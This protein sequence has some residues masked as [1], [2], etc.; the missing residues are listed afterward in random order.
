MTQYIARPGDTMD[1]TISSTSDGSDDTIKVT[2]D[3]GILMTAPTLIFFTGACDTPELLTYSCTPDGSGNLHFQFDVPSSTLA[4]SIIDISAL[5]V[6]TE[7]DDEIDCA[8]DHQSILVIDDSLPSPTP[9]PGPSPTPVPTEACADQTCTVP[10]NLDA[11]CGSRDVTSAAAICILG[12]CTG[13]SEGIDVDCESTQCDDP[14][15]ENGICNLCTCA[16]GAMVGPLMTVR[17]CTTIDEITPAPTPAVPTP[18][19]TPVPTLPAICGNGIT[20]PNAG[21]QCD[22]VGDDGTWFVC[23]DNCKWAPFF[24]S[25]I[26]VILSLAA[27][28]ACMT[29][30]CFFIVLGGR[31]RRRRRGA[32]EIMQT[33]A[34]E[35]R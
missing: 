4:Q 35:N 23:D 9:V 8:F 3:A 6:D 15:D 16:C 30:C 33:P 22:G 25:W 17:D 34:A 14:S 5:L 24:P 26:L 12:R 13:I 7:G 20:E 27:A 11:P 10:D 31:R 1:V 19:P 32:N 29:S 21:E 28:A 18:L 2:L